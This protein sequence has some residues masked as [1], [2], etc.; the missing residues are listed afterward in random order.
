VVTIVVKNGRKNWMKTRKRMT[1]KRMTRWK[2]R[3]VLGDV[4]FDDASL[5]C[6]S[7]QMQNYTQSSRT[8]KASPLCAFDDAP[9][10]CPS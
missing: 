8:Y 4:F 6:P 5:N 9:L 1:R 2:G 7:E 10:N 3:V